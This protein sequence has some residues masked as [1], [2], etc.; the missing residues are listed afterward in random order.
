MGLTKLMGGIMLTVLF[1]VAILGY[2]IGFATDNNPVISLADDPEL[3]SL[4]TDSVDDVKQISVETNSSIEALYQ[5]KISASDETTET[6]GQ[7]K[8]GVVGAYG[9]LKTITEVGFKKI[10]GSDTGFGIVLTG[11]LAFFGFLMAAY[12]WKYWAGK[13][14]D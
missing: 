3:A 13:N 1:S 6:G 14:P 2:M 11:L 8:G 9:S 12:V 5:S 4:Q 7:I 10:F